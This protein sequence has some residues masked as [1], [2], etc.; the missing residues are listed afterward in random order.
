MVFKKPNSFLPRPLKKSATKILLHTHDSV[1]DIENC[2]GK[3]MEKASNHFEQDDDVCENCNGNPEMPNL[4]ALNNNHDD[5][6]DLV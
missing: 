3:S 4:T 1:E 6:D 2:D 5:D